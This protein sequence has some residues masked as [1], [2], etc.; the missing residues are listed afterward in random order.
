MSEPDKYRGGCLQLTIGL[1]TGSPREELEK[2]LKELNEVVCNPIGTTIT[3]NQT[4]R[5]PF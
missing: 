1:S 2:G 5:A 4:P 3:T